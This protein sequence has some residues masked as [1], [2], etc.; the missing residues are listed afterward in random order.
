MR[1]R[2]R[3]GAE[4]GTAG[5]AAGGA[6][7]AAGRLRSTRVGAAAG[8]GPVAV[9][10]RAPTS[11]ARA[12][13]PLG[14]C[15]GSGW[16]IDDDDNAA[17]CESPTAADRTRP[18][19][20]A[21]G[22]AAEA[23][24]GRL[25]RPP[26]GLRHGSPAGTQRDGRRRPPLLRDDRRAARR[27]ARPVVDGRPRDRQDDAGDAG[28]EGRDRRRPD[29][30]DLLDPGAAG[31][32]PADVR[33]RGQGGRLP[34][35]L[36]PPGATSTSSTSTTSA[37]SAAR[38]WVLEQLYAIIDRRY[39]DERSI[40]FTTNLEEPELTEQVGTRTVSR[41]VEMCDGNPLPLFGAGPPRRV[42]ARCG[43]SRNLHNRWTCPD[44]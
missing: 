5:G 21:Q 37:P 3:R 43:P 7:R 32:D 16:L 14:V 4:A 20:R 6:S 41:L 12:S 30:C 13:C 40:V 24:P 9:P 29:R 1:P 36:R 15:D 39:N 31:A 35:L 42:G 34:R 2:E 22:L 8:T 33:R 23:L 18:L 38:D 19:E 17:P 10:D 26:A 28:L 27:R 11:P 44:W 25:L